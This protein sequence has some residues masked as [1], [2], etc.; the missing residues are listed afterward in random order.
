MS[1]NPYA[2]V[3]P[4]TPPTHRGNVDSLAGIARSVFLAWEKLRVA[5]IAILALPTL[6]FLFLYGLQSA[7]AMVLIVGGAVVANVCYMAG[8]MVETYV[9]WLGYHSIWP[10]IFMFT[11]GTLLTLVVAMVSLASLAR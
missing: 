6:L 4:G 9:R 8:P 3:D 1:D 2:A 10:R 11:S 7:S 5:F